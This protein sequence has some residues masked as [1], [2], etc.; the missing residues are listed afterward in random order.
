MAAE[1][2]A[3]FYKFTAA[4]GQSVTLPMCASIDEPRDYGICWNR[5][6][7]SFLTHFQISVMNCSTVLEEKRSSPV[8]VP[9][10][11]FC[12]FP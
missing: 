9:M 10:Q 8:V 11:I 4:V 12:L 5:M 7:V 2:A 6:Y 1:R 3:H